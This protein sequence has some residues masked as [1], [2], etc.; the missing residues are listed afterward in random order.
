MNVRVSGGIRSCRKLYPK[1]KKPQRAP[2]RQPAPQRRPC[3][4]HRMAVSAWRRPREASYIVRT[5]LRS[6][7]GVHTD[8]F[9]SKVPFGATKGAIGIEINLHYSTRLDY[10]L[11][12]LSAQA[13][14]ASLGQC[15]RTVCRTLNDAFIF[16]TLGDPINGQTRLGA[17]STR[18]QPGKASSSEK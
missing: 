10:I 2:C 9:Q 6:I 14:T 8:A 12:R 15:R 1:K 7:F 11:I 16:M 17:S 13:S 4:A 3:F 5:A 18:S